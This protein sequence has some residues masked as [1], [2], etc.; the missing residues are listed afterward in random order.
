MPH[1]AI[2]TERCPIRQSRNGDAA[3]KT[4]RD[5]E[6]DGDESRRSSIH[7]V[8]HQL[9]SCPLV[10][11]REHREL[12]RCREGGHCEG[13]ASISRVRRAPVRRPGAPKRASARNLGLIGSISRRQSRLGTGS[14]GSRPA[15]GARCCST[16]MWWFYPSLRCRKRDSVSSKTNHTRRKAQSRAERGPVA[17]V[18]PQCPGRWRWWRCSL[19]TVATHRPHHRQQ[20]LLRLLRVHQRAQAGR[21][22]R[23]AATAADADTARYR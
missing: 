21:R 7:E 3:S 13:N 6:R 10:D 12:A 1:S 17:V 22:T 8:G 19:R 18:A 23:R 11:Q 5:W 9:R 14:T 15:P 4:R 16:S 20:R 2:A